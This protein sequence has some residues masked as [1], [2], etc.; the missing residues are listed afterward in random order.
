MLACIEREVMRERL[1]IITMKSLHDASRSPGPVV[2]LGSNHD[3]DGM[4][5]NP[6]STASRKAL[7]FSPV[8]MGSAEPWIPNEAWMYLYQ[9]ERSCSLRPSLFQEHNLPTW[10]CP[11]R[12]IWWLAGAWHQ[13]ITLTPNK[14]GTDATANQGLQSVRHSPLQSDP[15]EC[16]FRQ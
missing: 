2:K 15:G 5:E 8:G 9:K 1:D 3:E 11:G 7:A 6:F 14:L 10:V 12:L 13:L 16:T 4:T